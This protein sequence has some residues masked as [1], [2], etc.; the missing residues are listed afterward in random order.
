MLPFRPSTR[1]PFVLLPVL[2]L[3]FSV[4]NSVGFPNSQSF[5][6]GGVSI[7]I[8]ITGRVTINHIEWGGA[9]S[10]GTLFTISVQC[11]ITLSTRYRRLQV[12][13]CAQCR[14]WSE[15]W[16]HKL[17]CYNLFVA[18]AASNGV[19]SPHEQV[20]EKNILGQGGS[21]PRATYKLRHSR[22]RLNRSRL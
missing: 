7:F 9:L 18:L 17:S 15:S 1:L 8:R 5:S 21:N 14:A 3:T 11:K 4:V 16:L 6:P 10:T 20:I 22:P 13:L 19:Y 2:L 12:L